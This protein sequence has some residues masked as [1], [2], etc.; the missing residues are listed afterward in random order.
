MTASFNAFV[1]LESALNRRFRGHDSR[2]WEEWQ[3]LATTDAKQVPPDAERAWV[4]RVKASHR[5]I[6][7]R[8][9]LKHLVAGSV[10]QDYLDEICLIDGLERLEL[11]H[12]V[13]ATGLDGL[14]SLRKLRHLSID[15]PRHVADF[16]PLLDL[17]SLKTL[18]ITNAKHLATIDWLSGAHHLEVVGIEGSTWTIQKI[19][20]LL[21][22]AGLRGLR[23]FFA[24]STRLGDKS[25]A[26]LADCPN[27][28]F[29]GC[30]N[31]APRE[32]FERL[33]NRKPDLVCTWFRP[34]SWQ[35]ISC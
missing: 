28:E 20:S 17:P 34:E 9:T 35:M 2:N 23:A 7:K 32:E 8:I 12:P 22:L 27:L 3:T 31:F 25:L 4:S 19:P 21:P 29:L 13:T 6:S 16:M 10:N 14:R 24:V 15:S 18:L 1:N 5:G 30:A 11:E 26:S 33:R